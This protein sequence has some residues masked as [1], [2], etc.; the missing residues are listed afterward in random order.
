MKLEH[1]HP[2][3]EGERLA[4]GFFAPRHPRGAG[5]GRGLLVA[6]LLAAVAVVVRAAPAP[7]G[8]AC[9]SYVGDGTD[10][11]EVA[12]LPFRPDVVFVKGDL[13]QPAVCRS[14][15]MT[16]DA[17][18]KPTEDLA[19]Q[20]NLI[21]E[22]RDDGFVV[23][24]DPAVNQAGVRYDWIA[25]Q[26]AG[27][28]FMY[29]TYKG[30]NV[31]GRAIGGVGF[32]PDLVMILHNKA[33]KAWLR[34]AAMAGDL[35]LPFAAAGGA[36][37]R[38]QA[39]TTT[40]F[41]VGNDAAVNKVGDDY[42]WLAWNAGPFG[43]VVGSFLGD[44][45]DDRVIDGLG[46][47]PG[48]VILKSEGPEPAVQ[49]L[50][51]LGAADST[52][53]FEAEASFPDGLQALLADGF[54]VGKRKEVNEAGKAI[55]FASFARQDLAADLRLSKQAN[56]PSAG[57]GAIVTYTIAVE[58]LGPGR[59]TGVEVADGLPA[60]LTLANQAATQGGYDAGSG[61]WTVGALDPGGQA[62]LLLGARVEA[63][64]AG[65]TVKNTARVVTLDQ[66]DPV[67]AN[68]SATAFVYVPGADL[69]VSKAVDDPFPGEGD[70]VT[71]TV[72]VAND[73]PDAA[74]NVTVAD[75]LPAGLVHVGS[76]A[77]QG[78]YL[79][80]WG[81]WFVGTLPAGTSATLSLAAVVAAGTSGQQLV[82]VA[83]AQASEPADPVAAD[84]AASAEVAV[85]GTDL[86]VTKVVDLPAPAE[87]SSITYTVTVGNAGPLATA[88]VVVSDLLPAGVRYDAHAASAATSYVPATGVWTVGDLGVGAV[89]TLTLQ[90]TVL[91]QTAGLVITNT[92]ALTG[93]DL[94]DPN[95]DNDAASANITVAGT[96]LALALAASDTVPLVAQDVVLRARIWNEGSNPAG[97]V[98]AQMT[99]PATLAFVSAAPSRGSYVP[100]SGAW[101]VGTVAVG[102]TATLDLAVR[103]LP[104]AV[105][106]APTV[107][108]AI[109]GS[110]QVDREP[111]DDTAAVQLAVAAAADLQLRKRVSPALA[112]AGDTL[113]YRVVVSNAGPSAAGGVAVRDTLAT[114]L[115]FLSALA[116]QGEYTVATG[117][118]GVGGLANGD[119]AALQL[120]AVV[121]PGSAGV[122]L[123]NEAA[124]VAVDAADPAP[125][126]EEARAVVRVSGADL[127]VELAADP[128]AVLAGTVSTVTVSL[129]N[130]GPDH[131]TQ[132]RLAVV[133]PPQLA[134][135]SAAPD[136]GS[137]EP[138]TG[139]WELG[140]LTAGETASLVLALRA[141]VEA[142]DGVA[143]V[144]AAVSAVAEADP[145]PGQES[146]A[147][148]L[149]VTSASVAW[150]AT[151]RVPA[152]VHPGAAVPDLLRLRLASAAAVPETLTSLTLTNYGVGAGA[153]AALDAEWDSLA[154]YVERGG[155]RAPARARDGDEAPAQRFAAG[156][157]TFA[158]LAEAVAPGDTVW[159][160]V[161]GRV[162]L[163]AR[164]G[165]QLAVGVASADDVALAPG[166]A[167]S[168]AWPLTAGAA[169]TVDGFVAA[170]ARLHPVT[171]T[172][173]PLG[174]TRRLALDVTLPGN[175]YAPDRLQR[176]NVVN[177]G[178]A[179]QLD[180]PRLEA[181]ADDGDGV[182]AAATD[183]RLG[184][185]AFTGD[186]WELTG[187]A[188]DVP[189][190]GSRVF[191]TVDVAVAAA[192]GREVRLALPGPP[193]PGVGLL[194]ANDGPLDA[195]LVNP[196]GL[197]IARTDRLVVS[198]RP[199][200]GATVA[201]GAADVPLLALQVANPDTLER[202]LTALAVANAGLSAH[203]GGQAERDAAFSRLALHADGDGDGVFD[204][205]P[206][207]P[208]L[209]ES[210]F[211]GGTAVFSG[212]D[213]TLAARSVAGLWVA[214]D[215]S[216]SAAADG[217]ALG[218][219]VAG[220][221]ALSVEPPTE[222]TAA[223]WPVDGGARWTVD[224]LVA[225]QLV[226]AAPR[227]AVLGPGD[228]PAL[229]LD[230]EVPGNGYAG[231]VLNGLEVRN[232][233]SA[234]PADLADMRLWRDGGDGVFGGDDLDLAPLVPLAG[235][236]R[237][238][239][240]S[241]ALPAGG[242][243]LF[244][245]VTAAAAL[246]DSATVRLG[247]P[248]NGVTVASGND[249]PRD[250]SVASP[251]TLLLSTAPL[252]ASLEL[253][254]PAS[255]LG[256]SVDLRM[257]VRNLGAETLL[258]V[259]PADIAVA[260]T[261]DLELL[262]EPPA[263]VD[264]A[265]DASAE[266]TWT[267]RAA[268]VGDLLVTGAAAGTG[269]GDGQPRR[270]LP[271]SSNGHHVFDP[272]L[273][274]DLF[275]VADRPFTVV[276]GQTGVV[277]L[278]LTLANPNGAAAASVRVDAL[279]LRLEDETGA[280]VVPAGLLSRV[281]VQEGGNVYL[282]KTDVEGTGA[283]L[284]LVFTRPALVTVNEPVT[285]GVRV[286]IAA[287]TTVPRF[288]F[289]L[290][291][292]TGVTASDAV[293]GLP[294]SVQLGSG[295][296]PVLSG[297]G[298]VTDDAVALEV[299]AAP[300]PDR[301]AGPGQAGV[302][303]LELQLTNP[304]L[305]EVTNEVQAEAFAITLVDTLGAP[306]AEPARW[307]QSL[308]VEAGAQLL[309]DRPLA[310]DDDT[311]L[312]CA[313]SPPAVVAPGTPLALRV[314]G[315]IADAAVP[316]AFRARLAASARWEARDR[317]TGAEVPVV[318]AQSPLAGPRITVQAAATT[319]L[320]G[321]AAEFPPQLPV[322]A[323]DVPALTVV[324]RHPGAAGAA[325][326]RCQGLRLVCLD[327]ARQRLRPAT[328]LDR[329][330]V[331]RGD[332]VVGAAE[333]PGEADVVLALGDW[334]LPAGGET[335]LSVLADL[336]ATAPVGSLEIVLSLDGL[337]AVDANL[338]TPVALAA[339]PGADLP[340]G[341]G[342]T[343][344]QRPADLLRVGLAG[345]LP[346]VL[347]VAAAETPAVELTF[348]N[349]ALSGAGDI[350]LE[351]L[352]L[353]AAD[354]TLA[355]APIGAAVSR[356]AAYRDGALWAV[357]DT[358]APD[359]AVAVLRPATPAVVPSGATLTLEVRAAFTAAPPA[360]GLRLGVTAD[361]VGVRQ[362][363]GA[364]FAIRVEP[365]SGSSFPLWTEAGE[366]SARGLAASYSNFP[367]PFAAGR[368][369]TTFVYELSGPA[370]VTLRIRTVHGET[371]TTLAEG[372]ERAAGLHQEDRW[373]GRNERGVAVLNGVY[374][375][376]L[377]VRY[378]GG[379]EE[380]LRR[381]VAV[382]R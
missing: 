72:T 196:V 233:G 166:A 83:T 223:D 303:L 171:D 339:I 355:A 87:G 212:L 26:A 372:A 151:A 168:A 125:G 158:D 150:R 184:A 370:A 39:L 377:T 252:L 236:W 367:N 298:R 204:G 21:Q 92:A 202:R 315:R 45:S 268:V 52:L 104:A 75:Q 11:R 155:L 18:K 73:G 142:P 110:N 61:R 238:P 362:P 277:P 312:A 100:A 326:I 186:R 251:T 116:S 333:A 214:G 353:R 95:A 241:E 206:V 50:T 48:W 109:T 38:I 246:T 209:G 308:R 44:G 108:V 352:T 293:S 242:A 86:Y 254:V 342:L 176:L 347:G 291:D 71:F 296:Y 305:P 88:G 243:R 113:R 134:L 42:H 35:S 90:A 373:D 117:L 185:F 137:F 118:W 194:S 169:L 25:F 201:P 161:A 331:R 244:V 319:V 69:R 141:G 181:W 180:L 54:V 217:D 304:G 3:R 354:R 107:T 229:A 210:V 93:S 79:A 286:D 16:G 227:P 380:R 4:V 382:L 156:R 275:P 292:G 375:A 270:S 340:L 253:L 255:T 338:G 279:R 56:A 15:S 53:S 36:E 294:A 280:G 198:S 51:T 27:D 376:E 103:P 207:D 162:A 225:A 311:L 285:L 359:A 164:D 282:D 163:A 234:L 187:L 358:L 152:A 190:S 130:G 20:T 274:L 318:Y 1:H 237:S 91:S 119:S 257:T 364:L 336:E 138:G 131:A 211:A 46:Q 149:T 74:G 129:H 124:V 17:A 374:V 262:S 240:L 160:A 218:A 345:R 112:A 173:L 197:V 348:A 307:L 320:A 101:T 127:S 81:Q 379:A 135:E 334:T 283:D 324:L 2:W 97:G 133:W 14:A 23:G 193:E 55:Y 120:E 230:L 41:Q 122:D 105:G 322:G 24:S 89:A 140:A 157:L 145:T 67:A 189:P 33:K 264:L 57:V 267:W 28:E 114:G 328:Y 313:L 167:L 126:D 323:L 260:G 235:A 248:V 76:T 143:T 228:G 84:N 369:A 12:G 170:Q 37:N 213:V 132:V 329:V 68:D 78:A 259:L 220:P 290:V 49:R 63:A 58:N 102:D 250:A 261:G 179:D 64:A 346:V 272:A 199:L 219:V 306:L 273:A 32:Q 317:G 146:A 99:V 178:D 8:M 121:A 40:G 335:S 188:W 321:G 299:A 10:D 302:T 13:K 349:P 371:V 19:F 288:R 356:L 177:A 289:A 295:A 153:Q 22:L 327:Q 239:L 175:G 98:T 284:R 128:Q 247:L 47:A 203:G 9:G 276:R 222:V 297:L 332:V 6:A 183:P 357:C 7:A 325:P 31:D 82:N 341:S 191:V 62:L 70:T 195:A 258:G 148:D 249:G 154:L 65:D 350:V 115:Q 221:A 172:V 344:L 231:D 205:A 337:D 343:L 215:V 271:V 368:E 263:A 301:T 123:V 30:D 300:A 366:F 309:L 77:S 310:A 314:T 269:A 200:A 139:V 159:L 330:V 208:V 111:A 226:C 174:A 224:G 59:A 147:V 281:V 136:Q 182:F 144:T 381:K 363:G 265:P 287:D 360:G 85:N 256:Q 216:L 80:A 106:A 365:E 5:A 60:T 43:L 266:F 29:G 232:L 361:D 66:D 245:S 34:T 278:M 94:V 316:G 351:T 378:A 96:N 165:D 192:E